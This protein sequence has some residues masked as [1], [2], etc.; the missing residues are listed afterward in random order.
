MREGIQLLILLLGLSSEQHQEYVVQLLAILIDQIDDNKW[1]ITTVGG[2][3][4]LVQLLEIG[5]QKARK[6]ATHVLWNLCCHNEDIRACVESAG[7][8]TTFLWLL[9]SGGLKGHRASAMAL[10]KLVRTFDFATINQLLALLLGDSPSS[11][12]HII[13]VLGHVQTVASHEDLAHK[14]SAAN[15]GLTSPV[16]VLNYLNEGT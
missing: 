9:K 15:K 1:A 13:R 14:G 16:Q 12:A 6:D 3:P 11:M 10:E 7:A 5:S 4:P 8:I 2:I